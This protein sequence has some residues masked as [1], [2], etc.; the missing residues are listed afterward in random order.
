MPIFTDRTCAI[1]CDGFHPGCQY[2][3]EHNF[4]LDISVVPRG[5][6]AKPDCEVRPLSSH[7]LGKNLK[8]LARAMKY[9]TERGLGINPVDI[10]VPEIQF[11]AAPA[12]IDQRGLGG[13]K[14][15]F[16]VDGCLCGKH[17]GNA[18][19][20]PAFSTTLLFHGHPFPQFFVSA[21]SNLNFIHYS[22]KSLT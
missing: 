15:T 16:D 9:Q 17:S 20:A 22:F 7:Q 2:L 13:M 21:H 8:R 4:Q 1:G 3:H 10:S 19:R 18:Q 12:E 6:I 5:E 14:S 11:S